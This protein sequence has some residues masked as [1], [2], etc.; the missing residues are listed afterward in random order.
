MKMSDG[1]TPSGVNR[2]KWSR[3]FKKRDELVCVSDFDISSWT[4]L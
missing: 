2:E 4:W 1:I 3:N